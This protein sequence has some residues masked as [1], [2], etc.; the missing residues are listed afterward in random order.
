MKQVAVFEAHDSYV[1]GLL[2]TP[3]S[4][5]LVSAGMD[6]LVKLWSVPDW[7]LSRTLE[8]HA[9]SVNSMSLSPDG[10]TLA[11]GST[12]NTVRLWS[13]DDGR[14]LHTLQDRRRTVSSVQISPDGRWV[15]SGSYGGRAMIWT[16]QGQAVVS[17]KASSKNLSSVAFSPD[18][19]LLAT[20]GLGGKIQVWSLPS[21]EHLETLSGHTTAVP[22]VA[23]V[24]EGRY[25]MSLGY[26]GTLKFW[27]TGTWQ[28]AR[29]IGVDDPRARGVVLSPD[30]QV[31]AVSVESEVQ[32]RTVED[33]QLMARLAVSTKV[34]NG[35]AFSGDGLW[36]AAGAADRKIRVWE[37]G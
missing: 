28:A 6:N 19:G 29:T 32:L 3:D 7:A 1:L 27:D 22:S 35:M 10:S 16:L 17:I 24:Q 8:G 34:V 31:I 11:T 4:Q 33:W 5:R 25:L 20:S 9:N 23:F 2:F 13:L 37:M 30:E 15:A 14:V 26:E 21:G 12:D 18:S 36:L